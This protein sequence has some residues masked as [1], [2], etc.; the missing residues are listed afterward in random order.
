MS[1]RLSKLIWEA[2]A[3]KEPDL[4]L[5]C[6][7]LAD[8][9]DDD[10]TRIFPSVQTLGK[11][12]RRSARTVQRNLRRL[13]SEGLIKA[14]RYKR[15]GRGKAREYRLVLSRLDV[16]APQQSEQKP[17]HRGPERATSTAQ[18]GDGAVSPHLLD[19]P[20]NNRSVARKWGRSRYP[21]AIASAGTDAT[22]EIWRQRIGNWWSEGHR[23]GP[24]LD[25]RWGVPPDEPGT[26][27]PR[28]IV[29]AVTGQDWFDQS[30]D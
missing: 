26:L 15:G 6:L 11:K 30:S 10:G 14:V 5:L 1:F 2:E 3:I 12:I 17:R 19:K 21:Q 24:W 23:T 9:A 7:A 13:E 16:P 4:L 28:D 20:T 18:Y 29:R 27:A 22:D 8:Y 25:D